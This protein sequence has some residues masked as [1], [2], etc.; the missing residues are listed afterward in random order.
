MDIGLGE[1]APDGNV[2]VHFMEAPAALL[3]TYRLLLQAEATA[4]SIPGPEG[5]AR[6]RAISLLLVQIEDEVTAAGAATAAA[7]DAAIKANIGK[8][9]VRPET[10]RALLE[11]AI[12]S[13]AVLSQ[14]AGGAVGIADMATLD[15]KA[16]GDSDG[17]PFWRAQEAGSSHLVGKRISG[18]F[19]PGQSAPDASQFRSHPIFEPDPTGKPMFIQRP[20]EARN[21]IRDGVSEADSARLALFRTIDRTAVAEM[22]TIVAGTHP[23]VERARRV[24]ERE[25]R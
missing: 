12:E 3:D 20:I 7:A 10:G 15:T 2:Y 17:Q 1:S 24:G 13:R 18:F 8:T 25:A 22:R 6:A 21:F 5:T 16:V 14:P 9:R 23:Y 19:Q 11:D 4:R